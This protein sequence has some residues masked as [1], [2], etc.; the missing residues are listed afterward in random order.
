MV[1]TDTIIT[2]AGVLIAFV[3]SAGYLAFKKKLQ[4]LALNFG[5]LGKITWD[6][7]VDILDGDGKCDL[8]QAAVIKK[9]IEEIWVDAGALGSIVKVVLD[10]MPKK[11]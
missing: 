6:F 4:D 9:T 5:I 3:S 11:V 8:A 2:I 1:E 10:R 7:V